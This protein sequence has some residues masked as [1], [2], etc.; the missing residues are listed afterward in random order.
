MSTTQF[1]RRHAR[2]WRV[3]IGLALVFAL[4]FSAVAA[5]GC[6]DE[7]E[8]ITVYSG[9]SQNLIGPLLERFAEETGIKVQVRYGGST[10]LALLLQE[11]RERTPADVFISRSPGP[12]GF[13]AERG[14]LAELDGDVLDLAPSSPSGYWVALT[15]RER[16]L[17]YNKELFD[18]ADLPT[19]VYELTDEEWLGRVALAPTNGS[20][21]DFFTLFRVSDGDEAAF[22]WLKALHDGGA[23]VLPEQRLHRAGRSPR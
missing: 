19:S 20:F 14:L 8:T 21:Q 18:P 16:V 1:F 15:G 9:R 4:P 17:V 22:A 6:S 5:F 3:L 10:D 7:E 13:L 11:E 23:P 2:T 12:I